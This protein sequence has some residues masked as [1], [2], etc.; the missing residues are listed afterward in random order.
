MKSSTLQTSLVYRGKAYA[1]MAGLKVKF[2][3]HHPSTDGKTVFLPQVPIGQVDDETASM[4]DGFIIHEA[5][6]HGRYTDFAALKAAKLEFQES[7]LLKRMENCIEDPRIEAK[8]IEFL[9]GTALGLRACLKVV[10]DKG[11]F[12]LSDDPMGVLQMYVLHWGR[13]FLLGFTEIEGHYHEAA[14]RLTE[15]LGEKGMLRMEALISTEMGRL[16]STADSIELAKRVLALVEEIAEEQEQEN[17]PDPEDGE[18]QP[19]ESEDEDGGED[20]SGQGGGGDDGEEE[21]PSDSSES[22][23][24]GEPEQQAGASDSGDEGEEGGEGGAGDDEDE[25]APS[26]GARQILQSDPDADDPTEVL[27]KALEEALQEENEKSSSSEGNGATPVHAD[28]GDATEAFEDETRYAEA[29]AA[30]TAQVATLR[31]QLVAL[32]QAQTRRHKVTGSRGRMAGRLL[33]RALVGNTNYRRQKVEEL[34]PVSA[35]SLLVDLSG[36]M[37]WEPHYRERLAQQV[38][39]AVAEACHALSVPLEVLGFGGCNDHAAGMVEIKPFNKGF[40][41]SRNRLG[42]YLLNGGGGTPMGEAML[43]A[44]MRLV[45]QNT[46]KHT[47]MVITDGDPSNR[48]YAV[49]VIGL[50]ERSG[51]QV[52]GIGIDTDAVKTLFNTHSVVTDVNSMAREVFALLKGALLDAA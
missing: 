16:R 43:E 6:G 49:E 52:I 24:E 17:T 48:D 7:P 40:L 15:Y 13:L 18:S 34:L 39:V 45:Q 37:Q 9:P 42:G 4:F 36:S 29:R 44:A 35:V 2:G 1:A 50:M 10:A 20:Q 21:Q 30:T 47:L 5:L 32:L 28:G 31:Q 23:E 41:P 25:N 27:G 26:S 46:P 22:D 38:T 51:I 11:W 8:A 33:H 3:R 19:D 12:D 14:A